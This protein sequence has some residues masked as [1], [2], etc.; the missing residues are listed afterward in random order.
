MFPRLPL[1][2]APPPGL[3]HPAPP[4]AP[5]PGHLGQAEGHDGRG[6]GRGQGADADPRHHAGQGH[7]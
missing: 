4:G 3:V 6:R 2:P 1:Q 5:A 7:V